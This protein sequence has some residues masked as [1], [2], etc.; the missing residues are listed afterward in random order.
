VETAGENRRD[1]AGVIGDSAEARDSIATRLRPLVVG[2][3]AVGVDL[4][5]TVHHEL[6]GRFLRRGRTSLDVGDGGGEPI[7]L[8]LDR[9]E[10]DEDEARVET[11]TL[12][13]FEE[14]AGIVR[15][16][17]PTSSRRISA[18]AWSLVLSLPRSR[19][20]VAW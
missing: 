9:A 11:G 1:I 13:Q 6:L 16:Q 3:D 17:D 15:D 7:A 20:L 18:R 8:H 14:V 19:T 4:D 12:G 2:A 5:D 10:I